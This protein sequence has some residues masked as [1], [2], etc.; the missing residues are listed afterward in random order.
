MLS[1][2]AKIKNSEKR[3]K[4]LAAKIQHPSSN[5]ISSRQRFSLADGCKL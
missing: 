1:G 4:I 5:W 2:I 3:L